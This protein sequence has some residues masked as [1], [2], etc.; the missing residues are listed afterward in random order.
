MTDPTLDPGGCEACS[1][2]PGGCSFCS[3]ASAIETLRARGGEGVIDARE[4]ISQLTPPDPGH[5]TE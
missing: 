1:Y 2:T 3:G 4:I 5:P